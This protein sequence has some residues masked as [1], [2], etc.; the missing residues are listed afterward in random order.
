[1]VLLCWHK[2]GL[3][4][5]I[6]CHVS[7]TFQSFL[8]GLVCCSVFFVI[9]PFGTFSDSFPVNVFLPMSLHVIELFNTLYCMHQVHSAD[10]PII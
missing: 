4:W 8:P 6:D 7:I 5:S 1:M 9:H 10:S 2:P 3:A